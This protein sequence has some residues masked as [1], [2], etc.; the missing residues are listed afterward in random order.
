[1]VVFER[2]VVRF[3]TADVSGL[4]YF[5]RPHLKNP[6]CRINSVGEPPRAV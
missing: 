6:E 1:M 2:A 3:K 5:C 4:N